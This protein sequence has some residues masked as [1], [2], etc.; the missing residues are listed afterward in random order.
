MTNSFESGELRLP[1]RPLMRPEKQKKTR[2]LI[3]M[4]ER[5]LLN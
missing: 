1:L 2:H 3:F 5:Q 4:N